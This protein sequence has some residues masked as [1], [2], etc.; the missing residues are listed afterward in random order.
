MLSSIY[1]CGSVCLSNGIESVGLVYF[2]TLS[3]YRFLFAYGYHKTQFLAG[4]PFSDVGGKYL[5]RRL[6]EN[7]SFLKV[8][9]SSVNVWRYG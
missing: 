3:H 5:L 1:L 8:A 2:V 7:S 9:G 4:N 6:T